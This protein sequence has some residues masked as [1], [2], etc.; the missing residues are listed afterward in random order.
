MSMPSTRFATSRSAAVT[1]GAACAVLLAAV[2]APAQ[3][4]NA[5]ARSLALAGNDTAVARAF[6][7]ISVNPAGL[8]MPGSDFSLA[9]F[10]VRAYVGIG[11][12]TLADWKA[13]E[14][15]L[16]ERADKLAWMDHIDAA[17]G[18]RLSAS[19]GASVFAL[20]VWNAGLQLST[21]VV[22]SGRLPP[23]VMEAVLFGNAG[24]RCA[25]RDPGCTPQP[26]TLSFDEGAAD[27]SATTTVGLS[28]AAPLAEWLE[29]IE[30]MEAFDQLSL[31]VT[32]TYTRGHAM[33]VVETTGNV[34]H[35]KPQADFGASLAH[36]RV[37]QGGD[38]L[39][40][41]LNGGSGIGLDLGIMLSL[42]ALGDLTVGASVRNVF[43][44]F[45]W[46]TSK[47]VSH[48]VSGSIDNTEIDLDF[49]LG[50]IAGGG[51]DP[52]DDAAPKVKERVE[53]LTFKPTARVGAAYDVL[54][55]LTV[56]GDVHYR[57][58]KGIAVDPQF[59]VGVGAEYRVLGPLHLRAGVAYLTDDFTAHLVQYGGG[60]SA[61]LAPANLSV[62]VAG[63]SNGQILGQLV[64]S[65][66]HR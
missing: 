65:F 7:A 3:L 13:H 49:D 23:D 50:D 36:T 2:P 32:V 35:D 31:G 42:E 40:H 6:G 56:S 62:A 27:L 22:A 37:V 47:L 5:S 55:D 9:V 64:L 12:I 16:V 46:D 29:Q 59:R 14:G 21:D 17:A 18:Q 24:R 20:T 38:V 33:A 34:P 61:I 1:A 51:G 54:D 39:A 15:K 30:L 63:Q 4:V 58:G 10:P 19:V 53:D 25:P 66:G 8:A 28:A 44:T 48:R 57:F 26:K 60:L 11:P 43:N 41:Y 52:Y 45:A